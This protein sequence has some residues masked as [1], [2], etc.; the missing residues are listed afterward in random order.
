M[1]MFRKLRRLSIDFLGHFG[2]RGRTYMTDNRGDQI[3]HDLSWIERE[4]R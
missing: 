2:Y 1:R 4:R 3:P